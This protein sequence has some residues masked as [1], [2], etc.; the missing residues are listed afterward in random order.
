VTD[1]QATE[2]VVAARPTAVIAA[3]TTWEEFPRLWREL[4]DEV[5][6]AVRA[7]PGVRPGRNVMLYRDDVP[8]VEIG[9]EVAEPFEAAGRVIG[10]T[11]PAG[12]VVTAT[13][14][15]PYEELDRGHRAVV[16]ACTE[17][18]LRRLGPRWEIYGHE[19]PVAAEPQVEVY[20]IVE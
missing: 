11:L 20:Y 10:S 6:R 18:G 17:R 2:L 16:E 1:P 12:K 13:H 4:L 19:A 15:G 9:V 14:R 3:T 8:H 5:W 7:G